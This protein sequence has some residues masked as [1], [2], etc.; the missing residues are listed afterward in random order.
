MAASISSFISMTQLE[1]H[2]LKVDLVSVI[3]I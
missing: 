1:S 2:A 3:Q